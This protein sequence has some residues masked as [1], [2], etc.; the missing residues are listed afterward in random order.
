MPEPT[1]SVGRTLNRAD[2]RLPLTIDRAAADGER[3]RIKCS[4]ASDAII[5]DAWNGPIQLAMDPAAIDL[6]YAAAHGLPVLTMHSRGLPVGRVHEVTLEGGRLVGV[7]QFSASSEGAALYRDCADGIITDTSVGAAI[8]AVREE[9]SHLVA[10]RWRPMEVS[11]VDR[12]ADPSVGINRAAADSAV[13]PLEVHRPMPEP[14]HTAADPA[15]S[16]GTGTATGGTP[17]PN[18][19][20]RVTNIMELA[21]Y[22]DGRAPELGLGKLAED[23]I[24]CGQPFE[25]YRAEVWKRLQ[26]RKAAEP[27]ITAP[28]TELGLTR[29]EAKNFSIVRAVN[30]YVSKDWKKAGFELECSRAIQD[31][32]NREPKGFFVPL[33]VQHD[34]GAAYLH[35][36]DPMSAGNPTYGGFLVGTEHRADLFIEAL[37]ATTIAAQAGVVYLPGLTGN[38]DI[39]KRTSNATFAW[40]REGQD[41]TLTNFAVGVVSATPAT[42]T[43]GIEM[44]R[45]SLQQ[46]NP[47]V[48]A[49]VRM[50]LVDGAALALDLA[51]FEGDGVTAPRGIAGHPEINT[52]S[53]STD[54]TPTWDE[55]VQFE[56]EVA[57]DNALSGSLAYVT[58]PAIV[59]KLKTTAK[60][61]GQGGFIAD[62]DGTVNGYRCLRSTQLATNRLLFGNWRMIMVCFWGVLD[63]KPDEA[64]KAASGGLV[65]RAFQDA[66][67][68]VRHGKAFAK[69]T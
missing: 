10:I 27:P 66:D 53:V 11:L 17:N 18:D 67:V 69:G 57:T 47:A 63:I 14:I 41:V 6:A 25:Q 3:R 62:P 4:F 39:P 40:I 38:I 35:R 5:D 50:D 43:G 19:A 65:I 29:R 51:I 33:E 15:G 55:I 64:T 54:T 21:R 24:Q 46:S 59:G 37:R 13:Q 12:G 30:A 32:M 20:Q 8:M 61:S 58:T 52:V 48:E 68:V 22:A 9:P 28:P 49:L 34:M 31:R 2:M 16:A 23:Y 44:T 36:A 1:D 56:T 60:A 26:E 7:I 45:R 42:L